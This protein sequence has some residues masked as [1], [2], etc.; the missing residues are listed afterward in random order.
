MA[1]KKVD[2][3]T[4]QVDSTLHTYDKLSKDIPIKSQAGSIS[5]PS[6]DVADL[7]SGKLQNDVKINKQLPVKKSTI[8]NSDDEIQDLYK[9][10]TLDITEDTVVEFENEAL[11]V[12]TVACDTYCLNLEGPKTERGL[13]LSD[14]TVHMSNVEWMDIKNNTVEIPEITV[15]KIDLEDKLA[16]DSMGEPK[17]DKETDI[18]ESRDTY[19]ENNTVE[20]PEITVEEIDLEPGDKPPI[21][22]ASVSTH[23]EN[24]SKEDKAIAESRDTYIENNTVEIPEITAEGIDIDPGDKTVST[25]SVPAVGG[26]DVPN[27]VVEEYTGE[28]D[29]PSDPTEVVYP[30]CDVIIQYDNDSDATGTYQGNQET[31][32]G[33]IN[34]GTSSI[35]T[36][37]PTINQNISSPS[38][39]EICEEA[40]GESPSNVVSD[41]VI[42]PDATP[43]DS[44]NAVTEGPFI[45]NKPKNPLLGG[46]LLDGGS[47]KRRNSYRRKKKSSKMNEKHVSVVSVKNDPG[48]N[49]NP[50]IINNAGVTKVIIKDV[51]TSK[52][53]HNEPLNPQKDINIV[54]DKVVLIDG[55]YAHEPHLKRSKI[56][57]VPQGQGIMTPSII[58]TDD[59]LA[60]DI[61][62]SKTDIANA[63][64]VKDKHIA[65]ENAEPKPL[66]VDV[67][68]MGGSSK[69]AFDVT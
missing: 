37:Y 53:C 54:D 61:P 48:E 3:K 47:F 4:N 10:K 6:E 25:E 15:E 63:M 68:C 40:N 23:E 22:P 16:I 24:C 28:P 12:L 66:A 20:I 19:R 18:A 56:E 13:S 30:K 43:I 55:K 59:K 31:D 50:E 38:E 39:G 35:D 62:N 49:I 45:K 27:V 21:T 67:T 52:V 44:T 41:I 9:D 46:D 17:E 29:I 42:D 51:T 33:I 11:P 58:V 32:T 26:I 5:V 2:D 8:Q 60:M 7:E 1:D 64:D 36:E 69:K 57:N 14:I 65:K 34:S